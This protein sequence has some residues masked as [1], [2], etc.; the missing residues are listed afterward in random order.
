VTQ[1]DEVR[2]RLIEAQHRT[3]IDQTEENLGWRR[4][5]VLD[6]LIELGSLDE[7][8]HEFEDWMSREENL[9]RNPAHPDTCSAFLEDLRLRKHPRLP[10]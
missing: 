2:R 6:V 10:L 1:V 3:M 7:F 5:D 4:D 8:A 9:R